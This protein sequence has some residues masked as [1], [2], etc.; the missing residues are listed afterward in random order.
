MTNLLSAAYILLSISTAV[1]VLDAQLQN[2]AVIQGG[3]AG[4]CPSDGL[5][6]S[7]REE[8]TRNIST[9]INEWLRTNCGTATGWTRVAYLNMTDPNQQCP[10]QWREYTLYNQRLCGR[11]F[12]QSDWRCDA[13]FY[14]TIGQSYTQVCGRIIGYR[15]DD[16]DGYTGSRHEQSINTAYVDGVSLTYGSPRN[17]IWSF[18]GALHESQCNTRSNPAPYVGDHYFCDYGERLWD[19][20]G[21]SNANCGVNNPPWFFATLSAPTTESLEVRIC[22]DNGAHDEDTPLQLI[23]IYVK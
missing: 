15:F 10:P 5:R 4:Q 21:C 9:A 17:H 19:G 16:P 8:L 6:D 23:E 1:H 11:L 13:N 7:M 20:E 12:I 14:S 2:P 22:G 3:T 18:Y